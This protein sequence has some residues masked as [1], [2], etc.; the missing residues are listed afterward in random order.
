[1]GENTLEEDKE[2]IL[3]ILNQIE[4]LGYVIVGGTSFIQTTNGVVCIHPV[5]KDFLA[6]E[7]SEKLTDSEE[8]EK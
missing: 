1:M 7:I 2:L 6:T 3:E 8:A 5:N 4:S